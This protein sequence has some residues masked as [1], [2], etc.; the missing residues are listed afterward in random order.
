MSDLKLPSSLKLRAAIKSAEYSSDIEL[1]FVI[2]TINLTCVR[3]SA[4]EISN[5]KIVT[6]Y[7]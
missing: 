3:L 1:A 5:Q 6:L 4:M 2:D 7:V